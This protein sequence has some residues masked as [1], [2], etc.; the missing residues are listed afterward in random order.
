[1]KKD[2][3]KKLLILLKLPFVCYFFRKSQ[4]VFHLYDSSVVEKDL[5]CKFSEDLVLL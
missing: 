2:E 3:K 4:E 1:M 5:S